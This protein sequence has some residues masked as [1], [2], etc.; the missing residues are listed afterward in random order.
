MCVNPG[1]LHPWVLRA[2][3]LP[4][5]LAHSG[6]PLVPLSIKLHLADNQEFKPEVNVNCW[7]PTEVQRVCGCLWNVAV[8]EG[9]GRNH[10]D[11]ILELLAVPSPWTWGLPELWSAQG[12]SAGSGWDRSLCLSL[13]KIAKFDLAWALWR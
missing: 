3:L 13:T 12:G 7:V 11:L 10:R 1:L 4:L 5:L 8:G 2:A 9:R 6:A